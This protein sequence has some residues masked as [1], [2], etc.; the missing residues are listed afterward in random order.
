MSDPI[1]DTNY[2]RR[3]VAHAM[4]VGRAHHSIWLGPTD[5]WEQMAEAHRF[6]IAENIKPHESV[7]DVGCGWGRAISLMPDGWFGA[8]LGMDFYKEFVEM[9]RANHPDKIFFTGDMRRLT[10]EVR[11]VPPL[12][13]EHFDWA[14]LCGIECMVKDNAGHDEWDK[15]LA[16]VRTVADKVLSLVYKVEDKGTVY[17]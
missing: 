17:Q 9:A 1:F 6:I 2:W 3:R 11:R 8:Y 7:I 5:D 14:I 16:Q 15:I 10:S 4:R 12:P 13:V